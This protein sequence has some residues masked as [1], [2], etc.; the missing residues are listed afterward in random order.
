MVEIKCSNEA[1]KYKWDYKGISR[2]YASCP[3]CRRV[4]KFQK[5]TSQGEGGEAEQE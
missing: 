4:N 3:M 1:C 2:F 5:N